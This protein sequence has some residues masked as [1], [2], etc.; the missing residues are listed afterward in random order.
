MVEHWLAAFRTAL[1]DRGKKPCFLTKSL[2]KDVLE[3]VG[4]VSGKLSITTVASDRN[5]IFDLTELN[6][7]VIDTIQTWIFRT[8]ES[9]QATAT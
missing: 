1:T 5:R 3:M 9:H 4:Q 8:L 7:M 6:R 2:S